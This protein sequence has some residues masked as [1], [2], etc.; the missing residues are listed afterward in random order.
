MRQAIQS[1]PR[2][3]KA[4]ILVDIA[5]G[6]YDI[7]RW[8]A[9]PGEWIRKNG[10]RS[11]ITPTHWHPISRD[12]YRLQEDVGSS[13]PSQLLA[14]LA[15]LQRLAATSSVVMS[16]SVVIAAPVAVEPIEAQAVRI[17]KKRTPRVGRR[18]VASSTAATLVATAMLGMSMTRY[19]DQEDTARVSTTGGRVFERE[20]PSPSQD[21]WK[22]DLLWRPLNTLAHQPSVQT[23]DPQ[24]S[25][26]LEEPAHEARQSFEKAQRLATAEPSH[27]MT[28]PRL[29]EP[30][31]RALLDQGQISAARRIPKRA[32]KRGGARAHLALAK[33][34]DPIILAKREASGRRGDA[35]KAREHHAKAHAGGISET[36]TRSEAL[37]H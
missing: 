37:D 6:T 4:V 35:M 25:Q 11:K 30:R 34:Y 2:D 16:D 33:T 9:E 19:T 27:E 18:F 13:K 20:A 3:G 5:S 29:P 8:S 21:W 12:P 32:A 26:I 31:A 1:E 36:K 23:T 17:D 7:A 15:A 10:K 28:I 14:N 22:T 24:L